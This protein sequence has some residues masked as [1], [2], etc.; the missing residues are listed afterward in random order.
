[1]IHAYAIKR[2]EGERAFLEDAKVGHIALSTDEIAFMLHAYVEVYFG[3]YAAVE[4][5]VKRVFGKREIMKIVDGEN[6]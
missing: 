4:A 3:N 5:I 6:E 1:M 2:I